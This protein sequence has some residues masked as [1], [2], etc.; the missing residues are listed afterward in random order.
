[1]RK[2][3]TGTCTTAISLLLFLS[4]ATKKEIQVKSSQRRQLDFFLT[5]REEGRFRV[6]WDSSLS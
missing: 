6:V 3:P 1:M 4:I 2:W 5:F